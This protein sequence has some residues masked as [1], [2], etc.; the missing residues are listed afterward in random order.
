MLVRGAAG[1]ESY[2]MLDTNKAWLDGGV[3]EPF[4]ILVPVPHVDKL[5]AFSLGVP[6]VSRTAKTVKP[7]KPFVPAI[8]KVW[9]ADVV[10]EMR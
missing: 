4:G 7:P 2:M 10:G 9:V 5:K 1:V 6:A 8:V 3:S